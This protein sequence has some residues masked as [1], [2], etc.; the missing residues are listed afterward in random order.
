MVL[1]ALLGIEIDA[2]ARTVRF[3]R[4]ILPTCVTELILRGVRVGEGTA[5]LA[6]HQEGD[7]VGVRA[8][9]ADGVTVAVETA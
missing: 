6:V 4:P 2:P 5:D 8:L 7:V 9:Y 1:S 3:R